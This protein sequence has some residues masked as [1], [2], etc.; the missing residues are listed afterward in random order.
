[1]SKTGLTKIECIRMELGEPDESGRRRPV[2]IEGSEF[3]MELDTLIPAIGEQPDLSFLE[4]H[5]GI[6]VSKWGTIEVDP[7]T[8]ATNKEGL[9]AG[10]DVVT[11]ANTVVEAMAAGKTVIASDINP[12]NEYIQ[13]GL[14]G[15][16][17]KKDEDYYKYCKRLLNNPRLIQKIGPSARKSVKKYDWEKI[18]AKV[19]E[20]YEYS[21]NSSE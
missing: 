8:L 5:H 3:E 6:D 13:S 18:G 4:E 17:A 19:E 16:L 1:M 15:Y 11:G 7:E 20:I 14:N 10:G 12:H 2:P 9:F 21:K